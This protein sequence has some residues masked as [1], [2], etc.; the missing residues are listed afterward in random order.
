MLL[1]FLVPGSGPDDLRYLLKFGGDA[2]I[3]FKL[4]HCTLA[5]CVIDI[6]FIVY[7]YTKIYVKINLY[8]SFNRKCLI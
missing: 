1:V 5:N 8:F 3:F 4:I 6:L 2:C 7:K